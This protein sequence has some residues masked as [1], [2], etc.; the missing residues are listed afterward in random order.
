MYVV[1]AGGVGGSRFVRGLLAAVPS[2]DVTVIVNTGD[3]IERF[4]LHISPDIDIN[5]Y[6]L[7]GRLDEE[8]GWGRAGET[9]ACQEILRTDFGVEAWFNLG[10]RDLAAHLYRTHRL[11]GGASLSTVTAEMAKAFGLGCRVL[12]MSDQPAA[13]YLDTDQG[14]MH[15]QEYLIRHRCEPRISSVQFRGLEQALPAPGVLAAIAGARA[16]LVPPS[17]PVVSV[18]PILA[19][20]GVRDAIAASAAPVVAVSPII[21]GKTV[22]GP[23]DRMLR[24]LGLEASAAGV[25]AWYGDLLDGFI[26]DHADAGLELGGVRVRVTDTWM[27]SPEQRRALAAATV[28]FAAELAG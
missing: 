10:D 1:F 27:S 25:A 7:S 18:G 22:K 26:I 21:G 28:A 13:T 17:N 14:T 8:R 12:P 4:G 15:F 2:E 6:A 16:I 23:A 5:L 11:Q 24:D 3:D 20:A 9:W 19:L